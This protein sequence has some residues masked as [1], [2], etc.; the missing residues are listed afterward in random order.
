[1]KVGLLS[2]ATKKKMQQLAKNFTT[3]SLSSLAAAI[4]PLTFPPRLLRIQYA[5]SLFV[6]CDE[7]VVPAH[8]VKPV[9]PILVLAGNIGVAKQADDFLRHCSRLWDQVVFVP[10]D[11]ELTNNQEFMSYGRYHNVH[12]LHNDT[13]YLSEYRAK[14]IGTP[15][16]T[17]ADKQF[18]FNAFSKT[19][20]G[21]CVVAVTNKIP[22]TG[23]IHSADAGQPPQGD[24]YPSVNAWICDYPPGGA[25]NVI[26]DNGV[27]VAYNA[28]GHIAGQNDITGA[29]GWRRD[30]FLDVPNPLQ[31]DNSCD[32]ILRRASLQ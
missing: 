23:V 3:V 31:T 2:K 26:Y 21:T 1:M 9:A 25:K 8:Y 22:D 6:D 13:H 7:K 24:L 18:L 20:P 32:E 17:L 10:G 27:L 12:R 5:S 15:L 16:R 29:K 28:R 14:I 30:A 19:E 11:Y 4:R